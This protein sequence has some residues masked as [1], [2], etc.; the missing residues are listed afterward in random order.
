MRTVTVVACLLFMS[1]AVRYV[2]NPSASKVGY[3]TYAGISC[4][5][6]E[7]LMDD[8]IAGNLDA[9]Q[10]ASI[11]SHLEVCPSCRAIHARKSNQQTPVAAV[12]LRSQNLAANVAQRW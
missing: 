1:A 10:V 9:Q 11:E 3:S 2:V 5:D 4:G 7:R 8:F 6:V 12:K